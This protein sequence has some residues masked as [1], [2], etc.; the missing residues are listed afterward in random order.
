MSLPVLL[1]SLLIVVARVVDVSMATMRTIRV[2]RGKRG[3]AADRKRIPSALD[4]AVEADPDAFCMVDDVR[5]SSGA[6][7]RA[8]PGVW[9][10]PLRSSR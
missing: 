7:L 2:V 5:H 4:A 10:R 8:D 1:T 3:K 6:R 9:W